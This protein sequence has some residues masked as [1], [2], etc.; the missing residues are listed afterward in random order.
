MASLYFIR[1]GQA[2]FGTDNYDRLSDLGLQQARLTGD[3]LNKT[4][5][6][7]DAL[8]SGTLTRQRQTAQQLSEAYLG[9]AFP[10]CQ[11]D[12]RLN[13]LQAEEIV[14]L[15]APRLRVLEPEVGVWLD[16]SASS[17]KSFQKVLR[18]CFHYWQ[19]LEEEVEGLESWRAFSTRI[20]ACVLDIMAA[21]GRGKNVAV[22]TSG[23]VVA[24]VVQRA[25]KMAD[26]GCYSVF[27]PVI[28]ASITHCLYS[29]GEYSLSYYND[30]SFLRLLG[31]KSFVTY[32]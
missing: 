23:G 5:V 18:R 19:A 6:Q 30:H 28:N 4:G 11:I 24:A 25:L 20:H 15:L 14:T 9:S 26:S 12:E 17:K 2:Q 31:D 16:E 1:H 7:F 8:Y 10:S 21:Q 13:E 22:C 3:Y 27:E 32:R 29:G